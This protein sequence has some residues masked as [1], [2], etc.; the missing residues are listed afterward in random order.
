MCL[1]N[2]IAQEIVD[3]ADGQ[4]SDSFSQKSAFGNAFLTITIAE[5][6]YFW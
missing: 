2:G 5:Q 6:L 1:R 3:Q 4:K